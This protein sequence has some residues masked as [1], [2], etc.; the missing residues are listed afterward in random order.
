MWRMLES[1]PTPRRNVIIENLRLQQV[2]DAIY[3]DALDIALEETP[4]GS[5]RRW[6]ER[7]VLGQT[8]TL[9]GR[10]RSGAG[11][12]DAPAARPDLREDR[13]D[14]RQPRRPPAGGRGSTE[15]SKLQSEAAPFPWD[16]AVR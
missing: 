5:V 15:L 4:I 16:E 11:P 9:A 3:A 8:D 10:D 12:G 6:F 13:P 2:Y 14:G 7:R 1:L